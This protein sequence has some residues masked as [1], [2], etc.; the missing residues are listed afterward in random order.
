MVFASGEMDVV[1]LRSRLASEA[2]AAGGAARVSFI[3]LHEEPQLG[4]LAFAAG[5]TVQA[6]PVGRDWFG[7][8]AWHLATH[9]ILTRL[10]PHLVLVGRGAEIIVAQIAE[11][12]RYH[13]PTPTLEFL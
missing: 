11:L 1:K 10:K 2:N 13:L 9:H 6:F 4:Q 7:D 12:P 5:C 3:Y 8:A